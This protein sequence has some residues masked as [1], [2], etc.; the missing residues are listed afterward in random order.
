MPEQAD[1]NKP[2]P[3]VPRLESVEEGEE[4]GVDG[5]VPSLSS[6]PRGEAN[7]KR[8]LMQLSAM[9]TPKTE[10][11]PAKS[12]M[13]PKTAHQSTM[14]P[15]SG[16]KLGFV[17]FASKQHQSV[18]SVQ[19]SPSRSDVKISQSAN[20][21]N[22]QFTFGSESV[23]SNEAQ[24]MMDT[25]RV[26][27]SRIKAEMKAQKDLQ[28]QK[29][30]E[31]EKMFAARKMAQPK[32][33]V[34][35]Y[36][37]VHMAQFKKMDSIENHASTFRARLTQAHATT[38]SLK[39][40]P[41]KAGLDEPQRPRT[42]GKGTPGR[43]PP[44]VSAR[45][46][47]A[48]P[49]KSIPP[50]ASSNRIE[51]TAPSKRLRR[52]EADDVSSSRP[53]ELATIKPSGIPKSTTTSSL[54]S[55]TKSSLM[56]TQS[57]AKSPAKSSM[58]PRSQTVKSAREA[59]RMS[60]SRTS[61]AVS[62]FTSKLLEAQNDGRTCAPALS[63]SKSSSDLSSAIG[64]PQ[65]PP[66]NAAGPT[67][68]S[69]KLPT[70]SGL[71]SILRS[72]RK[73]ASTP[74]DRQDTPKR[75]NTS[76]GVE[77]SPKKVDFTPSVKSR[78]AVK[79]A[80][81]SP[82]PAKIIQPD[83][84]TRS[85]APLVPYDSAAY[86]LRDGEEDSWQDASS[87]P[88]EYPT[89]PPLSVEPSPRTGPVTK[90]VAQKAKEAGHRESKEFKSIFTT[91]HHPTRPGS[92]GSL[93]ATQSKGRLNEPRAQPSSVTSSA[94]APN[95][96]SSR[97]STIR[98]VRSSGSHEVVQPFEDT[99]VTTMAHGLPAKKRR[100]ESQYFGTREDANEASK[101]NMPEPDQWKDREH[102]DDEG[103]KRTKRAKTIDFKDIEA[104]ERQSSPKKKSAAREAAARNARDRKSTVP[105]QSKG[106][107]AKGALSMSRLNMLSQPKRRA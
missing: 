102:S 50:S 23:L 25:V 78:Y 54:Y 45:N 83:H 90:T 11:R 86:V 106:T 53:Q 92:S 95:S 80:N 66:S 33:K 56:R 21:Q 60:F 85:H 3:N 77:D 72:P 101:E 105:G 51:N 29:E 24:Q 91:L 16:L 75:P 22:F 41:S 6:T 18:A 87:S 26:E 48:S 14:P 1:V 37:D 82:S 34:G 36:S 15:D 49:Y 44:L 20:P 46:A 52:S 88:I 10:P 70:F 89:L 17:D 63:R 31:A 103:E 19:N 8:Q 65:L 100:R 9:N 7:V 35:R 99:D 69:S 57:A 5:Q 62:K 12:E 73:D 96:R 32:A 68:F 64:T 40:S 47:T 27:A 97:P 28:T 81:N 55:P 98:R 59:G 84:Q 79:L 67:S 4:S 61:A 58:L 39:R 2:L 93:A 71:K 43:D 107:P 38:Q 94:G 30:G 13:E 104:S 74:A 76:A 42:A